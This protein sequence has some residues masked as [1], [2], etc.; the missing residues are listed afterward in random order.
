VKLVAGVVHRDVELDGVR[1][2]VAQAGA[3]RAV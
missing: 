3:G 2:H 1:L